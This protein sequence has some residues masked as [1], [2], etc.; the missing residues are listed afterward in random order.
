MR[1]GSGHRWHRYAGNHDRVFFWSSNV[2]GLLIHSMRSYL[3]KCIVGTEWVYVYLSSVSRRSQSSKMLFR[4]VLPNYYVMLVRFLWLRGRYR[5]GVTL[6]PVVLQ[7]FH[8]VMT[9][10]RQGNY[11]ITLIFSCSVWHVC[12]MGSLAS[13]RSRHGP[14]PCP[15]QMGRVIYRV[16]SNTFISVV[17]QRLLWPDIVRKKN[18]Y[19]TCPSRKNKHGEIVCLFWPP[20]RSSSLPPPWISA[21]LRRVNALCLCHP[22]WWMGSL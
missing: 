11:K 9:I 10:A 17:N 20:S 3:T 12:C 1:A 5:N 14:T 2:W 8:S 7:L 6:N 22:R 18:L 19:S 4:H 21:T 13:T 15:C 16:N